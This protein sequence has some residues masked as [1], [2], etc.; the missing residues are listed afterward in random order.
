MAMRARLAAFTA[1]PDPRQW[2]NIL[3]VLVDA[4][5]EDVRLA[6]AQ[7]TRQQTTSQ[8]GPSPKGLKPGRCKN[9]RESGQSFRQW[10]DDMAAWLVRLDPVMMLVMEIAS[11][12]SG[13]DSIAFEKAVLAKT[14]ASDM[15]E[16]GCNLLALVKK[17]TEGEA[18]DL[19]DTTVSAGEAW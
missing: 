5:E 2:Q 8:K 15:K 4:H 12:M 14:T 10:A 17:M 3:A 11:S 9:S 7:T 19:V 18:R 6:V 16:A 13:W 1:T